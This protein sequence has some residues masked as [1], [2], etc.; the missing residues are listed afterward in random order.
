MDLQP[1]IQAAAAHVREVYDLGVTYFDCVRL[2]TGP[3]MEYWK[4]KA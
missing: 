1:D 3:T 2:Y 4:K